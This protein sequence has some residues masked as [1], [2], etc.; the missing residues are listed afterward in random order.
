[1]VHR[2]VLALQQVI[3]QFTNHVFHLSSTIGKH[4]KEHFMKKLALCSKTFDYKDEQ[5]DVKAKVSKKPVFESIHRLCTIASKM[6]TIVVRFQTGASLLSEDN[7]SFNL[8]G[9]EPFLTFDLIDV[10]SL[11]DCPPSLSSRPCFKTRKQSCTWCYQTSTMSCR[12]LR[13]TSSVHFPTWKRVIWTLLRQEWSRKKKWTHHGLTYRVSMSSSY[14][15]LLT[16]L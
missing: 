3:Y 12:W 7:I 15:L 1:M 13:K 11:R 4:T 9:S 5:K 6:S 14:S 10:Y 2:V 16:S 8:H